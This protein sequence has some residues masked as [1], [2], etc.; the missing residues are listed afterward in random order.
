M[1]AVVAG[2]PCFTDERQNR[3]LSMVLHP[4]QW[5]LG[6]NSALGMVTANIMIS[7]SVALLCT[8]AVYALKY[9]LVCFGCHF[10]W[11]NDIP[12]TLHFPAV[13][14]FVW[15]FLY[16]SIA[17]GCFLLLF[18]T[19]FDHTTDAMTGERSTAAVLVVGVC[20]TL[21]SFAA[22][23]L[24]Y[25][26]VRRVVP[27][28]VFFCHDELTQWYQS[29]ALHLLLGGG[30]WISSETHVDHVARC[31]GV[32]KSFTEER[33]WWMAVELTASF[34][35][36]AASAFNADT[37][38]TC[39]H[40]KMASAVIFLALLCS[41]AAFSPHYRIRDLGLMCLA[42]F[43]QML[44]MV[45][46]ATGYYLGYDEGHDVFGASGVFLYVAIAAVVVRSIGDA[47]SELYNLCYQ[48]RE[49]LQ[50]MVLLDK[51]EMCSVNDTQESSNH[52]LPKPDLLRVSFS[53]ENT[54]ASDGRDVY[55]DYGRSLLGG[56]SSVIS[57]QRRNPFSMPAAVSEQLRRDPSGSLATFAPLRTMSSTDPLLPRCE[58][59]ISLLQPSLGGQSDAT[60]NYHCPLLPVSTKKVDSAPSTKESGTP[61][62]EVL[63]DDDTP[64]DLPLRMTNFPPP[65]PIKVI[66]L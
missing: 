37:H 27:D 13:P 19:R 4:T 60:S 33:A 16:Q 53:P 7:A 49:R 23:F 29:K 2:E 9:T 47:L 34:C 24:L 26:F 61:G 43:A 10:N 30:E 54:D 32:L 46:M 17:L 12:G 56:E 28:T 39:G 5:E 55:D 50:G 59:S 48:R 57:K 42:Y 18:N 15:H 64:D 31:G 21:L 3:T 14:L 41:E 36:A 65:A 38:T 40:R 35:L 62:E 20:G 58:G 44:A 45:L 52:D 1:Q 6:G 51:S 11:M 66:L 63:G 8:L 25:I 22:P